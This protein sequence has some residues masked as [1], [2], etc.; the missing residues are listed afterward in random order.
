MKQS[1]KKWDL[2]KTEHKQWLKK[3]KLWDPV[4]VFSC[5]YHD[6]FEDE[7]ALIGQVIEM[8]KKIFKVKWFSSFQDKECVEEFDLKDG[9]CTTDGDKRPLRVTKYTK[10]RHE[11]I[12][13]NWRR[14]TVTSFDEWCDLNEQE[15]EW[16]FDVL[17][18]WQFR[19]KNMG[20]EEAKK[21]YRR[22]YR[23]KQIEH[24][25]EGKVI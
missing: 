1:K 7:T 8:G 20:E 17:K 10:E 21:Y 5:S 19:V 11:Q 14:R 15:I 12:R 13:K 2:T 23:A 6:I 4:F 16:I 18:S 9:T 24:I 3:L 22:A 25:V